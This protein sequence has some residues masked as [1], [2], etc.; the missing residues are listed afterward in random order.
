MTHGSRDREQGAEPWSMAFSVPA[1]QRNPRPA[2]ST[3]SRG[4]LNDSKRGWATNAVA[5]AA[6]A[7]TRRSRRWKAGGDVS[8]STR[9]RTIP[10]PSV[11]TTT[12]VTVPTRS[13][14]RSIATG[15]PSDAGAASGLVNTAHQLGSSLGLGILVTVASQ[16]T[17]TGTTTPSAVVAHVGAA[18]SGSSL[19][20]A[21]AAVITVV[22]IVVPWRRRATATVATPSSVS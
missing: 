11:V 17:N 7:T 1:A 14:S 15:A 18:L 5:A 20:L 10:P 6:R 2:A 8:P 13:W 12:S 19:F 22:F 21:V 4:L 16:T 3:T 9:S